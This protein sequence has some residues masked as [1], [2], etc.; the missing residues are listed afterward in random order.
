MKN[1]IL[2]LALFASIILVACGSA[3]SEQKNKSILS[4]KVSNILSTELYLINLAKQRGAPV[5]TARIDENGNFSFDFQPKEMGFYRVSLTNETALI[6]PLGKDKEVTINGN[7]LNMNDLEIKG[8]AEAETLAEF[9]KF[10]MGLTERMGQLNQEFQS[11]ANAS[12]VDS[13]KPIF[14][15]RYNQMETEKASKMKEL[16]DRDPSSFSNLAIIEQL[17]AEQGN[18]IDYYSKVDKALASK[19]G[20]SVFYQSLH[21]K[22]VNLLKFAIGSDVPEIN[23]PDPSGNLVPLSSLRGQVVLIDFWASWCKPCRMEN[24]NVV[25]AYNQFKDKGFTVYGVS[26]DRTKDAWVSA[27]KQDGLT[28][29]HVSDLKFWQSVAA[30]D[31]GVTG[32]PFAL[33]ID[34]DGKVIGKNLRGPALQKKLAEVLN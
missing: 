5:D 3:Q 24:P 27:I 34:K 8:S 19:Y 12:N 1:Q 22:V 18:N 26:L 4:G 16:I 2:G 13:L 9:N 33:L 10:S 14:Q 28:W 25:N 6:L 32:I 7:A 15:A 30:K 29:T 23:L 17:P 20:N 31:Y 11:L 21:S